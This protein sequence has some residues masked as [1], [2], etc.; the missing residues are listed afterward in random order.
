MQVQLNYIFELKLKLLYNLKLY[1]MEILHNKYLYLFDQTLKESWM[2][3]QE[4]QLKLLA[5][6][7]EIITIEKAELQISNKLQNNSEIGKIEV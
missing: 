3:E 4:R 6:E 1:N 7:K 5:E 2:K